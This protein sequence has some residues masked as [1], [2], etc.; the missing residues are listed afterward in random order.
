LE[1]PWTAIRFPIK[2]KQ[3]QENERMKKLSS[4]L[5]ALSLLVG[6]AGQ[7]CADNDNRTR[8]IQE[9]ER[10]NRAGNAG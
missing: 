2:R 9:L 7:A 5:L 8:N 10:Q 4:A 3:R 1:R 6:V